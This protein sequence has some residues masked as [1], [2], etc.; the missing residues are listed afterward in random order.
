MARE[1]VGTTRV[2]TGSGR[3]PETHWK[4]LHRM[5]SPLRPDTTVEHV[6]VGPSGAF[7]ISYQDAG[8]ELGRTRMIDVA[9]VQ[10]SAAVVGALLPSRY[11]QRVRPVL[12][13]QGGQELAEEVTGV[14]V[15]SPFTLEHILRSSPP[16]LSTSEVAEVSSLLR[17]RLEQLPPPDAGLTRRWYR[18][19]VAAVTTA[20]AAAAA[21]IAGA[22]ALR[23]DLVPPV[24]LW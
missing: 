12:C 15:T 24:N 7:V 3:L 18:T 1:S 6:L 5:R 16:V 8:G 19:R 20:V 9:V 10:D 22:V 23:T 11:Q 21:S 14:M 13:L 4:Q 17:S 2:A